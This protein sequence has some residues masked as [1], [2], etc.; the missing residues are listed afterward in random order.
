MQFDAGAEIVYVFDTN[1]V[2]LNN[3]YYLDTYMERM[4]SELFLE[5]NNKL[6]Y[7]SKNINFYQQGIER[8]KSYNLAGVVYPEN[9]GFSDF[10]QSEKPFFVQGNFSPD[11]TLKEHPEY[12]IDFNKFIEKMKKLNLTDRKGWL[13]SLSHG[14]L[15]KT[16]EINVRHFVTEIRNAF[17]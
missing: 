5:F 12:L 10:L 17:S 16:P 6:A 7:F 3:S 15:P 1:S 11:S 14:V 9:D 13:C 4:K 2:Q 8:L